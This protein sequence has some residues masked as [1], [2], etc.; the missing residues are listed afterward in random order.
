MKNNK[1]FTLIELLVVIAIIGILASVVLASLGSARNKGKDA[2]VKSQMASI[3][4]QFELYSQNS[5]GGNGTYLPTGTTTAVSVCTSA[6]FTTTTND[7]IGSLYAG[8]ATAGAT[9]PFC[10]VT[11]NGTAW[12]IAVT[13]PGGGQWCVDSAGNSRTPASAVT[14]SVTACP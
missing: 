11:A 8:L 1:G 6:P 12:A 14:A 9:S 5:A 10:G 3:R 4:A 13:L 7:G 2:A